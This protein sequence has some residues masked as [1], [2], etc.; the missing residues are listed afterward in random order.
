M[1][2]ALIIDDEKDARF[3][4]RN[5]LENNFLEQIEI[6]GEADD[7]ET[8]IEAI[9]RY[10]PDLVFL[11]IKM[12]QG[13]G[14]NLLSQFKEINFEVIFVTAY[15]KF[16]IKAFKFSA[17]GYLMKPIKKDELGIVVQKLTDRIET[18]KGTTDKRLKILV[19]NFDDNKIKKLVIGNV[20]GFKVIELE[21]L[22]RLEGDGNY[23]NFILEKDKKLTSTKN[24]GEY[25]DL[26]HDHGFFR[27]HQSTIVNLKHV[28]GFN[29][30]EGGTVEMTDNQKLKLSRHR[31]ESF[32]QRF[33]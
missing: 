23:T 3:L 33:L 30:E 22:I 13:T 18:K 1:I 4:L 26:L 27:I 21:R 9:K 15:D 32:M 7:V 20:S 6:L 24:L 2:K 19:E 28:V 14:F 31:K 10:N 25:Q 29:R 5:M 8:G 16:A 11:D 17:F 12:P